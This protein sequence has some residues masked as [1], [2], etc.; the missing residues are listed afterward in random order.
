MLRLFLL[1]SLLFCAAAGFAQEKVEVFVVDIQTE[2]PIAFVKIG[3]GQTEPVLTDIDGKADVEVYAD[4][5]YR[6]SFFEYL[7]T[8]LSGS[9]LMND[10]V[11]LML[12]DIQLMDEVVITP[13]ENPAHR[14]IQNAMD[15]RKENDPLRNN[16]FRYNSYSKFYL[17]GELNEHL[18]R[19]TL[20]DTSTIKTLN[21][22]DEQYI[23]LTETGATRT[24][25]PPS[26]DKE[27]VTSY[28]VSGVKDPMF[29][30]LVNQF[31]SFSFYDNIF[32]INQKEYIN[33]I[34][35]G[36]LRRYLFILEDTLVHDNKDTTFTIKFRPRKG[37]NFEGLEGYLFVH[38]NNWA[39]VKV[40]ASPYEQGSLFD[41]KVIQSYTFRND[42]KWFPD[43]LSTEFNFKGL[44]IGKYTDAIGRSNL[45]I[46]DVTF[47]ID[48]DK[49]F[50]NPV[51]VEIDEDA[52]EDTV[53]LNEA[54]GT[55]NSGKEAKTYTVIDSISDEN[56]LGRM[57]EVFKILSTGKIPIGKFSLPIDRII[58]FNQQEGY[59]L[60]AGLETNRRLSKWFNIGGYFAYG[61]RD[62]EWKWGGDLNV[63]FQQRNDI[64]M[65]LH[66]SEDL[67]ERGGTNLLNEGFNLV[68]QSVY[69]DFFINRL[70]RQRKGQ[71]TFS[72]YLRQ[73]LKLSVFGNYKRIWFTD[74]YAHIPLFDP[75][76]T[77]TS[78][79]LAETGLEVMWNIREK[80]MLVDGQRVTL[81]SKYP[82]L[83][84]KAV[85]GWRGIAE[86]DYD[87]YRLF[88]TIDQD[89]SIRGLGK[90]KL[91]SQS[92]LTVGNVPLTLHQVQLGT[93]RNWNLS[94]A[95][96]FETMQP[97]EFF[98]DRQSSLFM[99]FTFLPIKLANFTQPTFV[100]HSAAGIGMMDNRA[101]HVNY[102][103]NVAEE[104]YYES[105][106]IIENLLV[107]G[108][109]GF[110]VGAFYRY[111]P[112]S[113]DEVS[114]NFVYKLS[115]TFN[116]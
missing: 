100:V 115:V 35:P 72:G 87:Y 61:F 54:R 27:V 110:G 25:S 108:F 89:F 82:R 64:G 103:F 92:G 8:T 14:I 32:T 74:D 49:R 107:S 81:S 63:K 57:L 104:G 84:L 80:I 65:Q 105:G 41:I 90:L 62:Q 30:T 24:F 15:H 29:A 86:S 116:F 7:D 102:D 48:V 31:Q 111:G 39:L 91:S 99:R 28:N 83:K 67:L 38:T 50:F 94:V 6:F 11:V 93:A 1:A 58:D 96:T 88:F 36:G 46:N 76:S 113:F 10:P 42:K 26:Y 101:E 44:S 21:L 73:N 109:N 22:L 60:G 9:E 71:V 34:A 16:S 68:D 56:N 51:Q 66:Y 78:F 52:K 19:D 77:S 98:A 79:D 97:A 112:Y 4:R 5:R 20:T 59:R 18:D 17:T 53:K 95:N 69:R 85:K 47:D 114:D 43:K 33:P 3:D 70:D 23:F 2:E 13:G 37:K 40:I 55:N 106:L 45:Y 75:V 12:P